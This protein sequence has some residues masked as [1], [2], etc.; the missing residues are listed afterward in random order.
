MTS[1]DEE[2]QRKFTVA[3]K[4]LMNFTDHLNEAV[5][6]GDEFIANVVLASAIKFYVKQFGTVN[7]AEHLHRVADGL[8]A[9][10]A[11]KH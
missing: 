3:S 2:R 7:T 4:L 10:T 8:P 6:L 11:Q 1:N 5:D 9:I